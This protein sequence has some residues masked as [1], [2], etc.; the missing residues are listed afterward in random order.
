MRTTGEPKRI[1]M[2]YKE[3]IE[4]PEPFRKFI[5]STLDGKVPL[6]EMILKVLTYGKFEDI[7]RLYGMYPE[8]TLSVVERY[9][10]IKRGVKYWVK[11][12]ARERRIP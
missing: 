11:R 3:W 9:P 5:W 1:K 2:I 4:V 6:E 12:W 7:K 8:E 10:D